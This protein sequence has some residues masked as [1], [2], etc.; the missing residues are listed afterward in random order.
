MFEKIAAYPA[1]FIVL[2]LV[3]IYF[4]FFF[5]SCWIYLKRKEEKEEA[6]RLKR[7]EE[8]WVEPPD[9]LKGYDGSCYCNMVSG[10]CDHCTGH[11]QREYIKN[12]DR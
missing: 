1:F 11:A 2:L 8:G 4:T 9:P 6:L 5:R 12:K 10:V 3:C 7:I